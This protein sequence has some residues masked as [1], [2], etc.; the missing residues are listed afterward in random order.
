MEGN[1]VTL[2]LLLAGMTVV[3]RVA[4]HA[5]LTR[6]GG[7]KNVLVGYCL[8]YIF[9]EGPIPKSILGFDNVT[10]QALKGGPM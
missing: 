9:T 10:I 1:S 3:S 4:A 2:D 8:I 7:I 6:F 5:A